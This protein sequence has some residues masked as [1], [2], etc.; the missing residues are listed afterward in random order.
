MHEKDKAACGAIFLFAGLELI[1]EKNAMRSL[2]TFS[3]ELIETLNMD[4]L[5]WG[6]L[7]FSRSK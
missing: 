5:L 4:L 7:L 6:V 2:I 1:K 3:L